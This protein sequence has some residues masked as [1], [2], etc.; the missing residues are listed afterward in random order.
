MSLGSLPPLS[1]LRAF[2][3]YAQTGSVAQAG[4][5][6]NVS[7]A[8]ISQQVRNLETHIGL[9]LLDRSNR[10][11]SLTANGEVLAKALADGFGAI[12]QCIDA[13]TGV[14][15][16][17]ALQI[18]TT[19]TLASTWLMPR[20]PGFREKH[21]EI[22]MMIDPSANVQSLEPGGF[23][24]AIRYGSGHWPGLEAELILASP[25]AIVAAPSL[26]GDAQI[27][28][29]DDLRD[30]H[31]IQELGTSE[32]TSWFQEFGIE[33]DSR[34]GVSAMPGNMML[35]AARQGQGVAITAKIFVESDV[36]AGRLRI[37]F[38]DK[39]KKG[40]HLVTRP[41]VKRPPLKAFLAWVR[42]EAAKS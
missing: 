27:T 15:A 6:L 36:Q 41:G 8:A 16:T 12:S 30:Y 17:R 4:A 19:P 1:A 7:H 31:W 23:D 42:R 14:D 24:V 10:Q 35:E 29:P 26:V 32:A 11:A 13:L 9:T 33:R 40:Y 3:A 39:R 18:S 22:S 5:M 38:E 2:A 28:A 20:L 34:K 21:P 37:L 25:V